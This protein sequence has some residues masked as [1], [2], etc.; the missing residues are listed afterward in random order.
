MHRVRSLGL[1]GRGALLALASTGACGFTEPASRLE[2]ASAAVMHPPRAAPGTKNE[3]APA[4]PSG[5]VPEAA[6]DETRAIAQLSA[7]L[8]AP[9]DLRAVAEVRAFYEHRGHRPAWTRDGHPTAAAR[10]ALLALARLDEHGLDPGR[11]APPQADLGG[12]RLEDPVAFELQLSDAWLTAA[13]HLVQGVVDPTTLHSTWSFEPRTVDRAAA[14][15]QGLDRDAA[16]AALLA[17]APR[18]PEYAA[19]QGALRALRAEAGRRV[20]PRIEAVRVGLERWRWLPEP[21]GE[22]HVRVNIAAFEVA[23]YEGGAPAVTM[24]AVVGKRYRKTPMFGTTITHVT[25][26]PHWLAPTKLAVNDLLPEILRDPG[27]LE[28]KGFRVLRARDRT[29]VDPS[30]VPWAELGPRR[31]PYLLWQDPGPTNSLGRFKLEMPNDYDIFLHDTPKRHLFEKERR[32]Y[33]SG[34]VRM[35]QP[36]ELALALLRGHPKWTASW[37]DAA[38]HDG[39]ELS[40]ALPVPVPA[41]FLYFTAW[42]DD[43]GGLQVRE[44]VYGWDARLAAALLAPAAG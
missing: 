11:Y 18:H 43:A 25:I 41:Y 10:E 36:R 9:L 1:R 28:R 31:F 40:I 33:S 14:L 5:A 44:D 34:C 7:R 2:P 38:L 24:R 13:S 19:L 8:Q 23:L 32:T 27:M 4:G 22:R 12:A 21:L 42:V 3:P 6:V 26:N 39:R 15:Q 29:A 30:A 20:D 35:E 16:G 37:L 17:L